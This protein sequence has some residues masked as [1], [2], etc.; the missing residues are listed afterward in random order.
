MRFKWQ[1]TDAADGF[2]PPFSIDNIQITTPNTA[3]VSPVVDA[4]IS[5]TICLGQSLNLG[6]SPTA[7]GGSGNGI[8]TYA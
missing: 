8:Y 4:G 3:C 5:T 1:E 6:G 2:D 7:T